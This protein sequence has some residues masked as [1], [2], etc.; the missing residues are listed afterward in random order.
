MIVASHRRSGT[1]FLLRSLQLTFGRNFQLYKTHILA[2]EFS[3]AVARVQYISGKR[4]A[5]P[6]TH[7]PRSVLYI[8]RDVRD[9]L[10]SNYYWWRTSAE[11]K[12]GGLAPAFRHVSPADYVNGLAAID[13]VPT[14]VKGCGVTQAHIDHGMF[15]DPAGFWAKHVSSY[16]ESGIAIIRFE[17]LLQRPRKTLKWIADRFGLPRPWFPRAP[18]RLVGHDP[19]KGIIGDHVELFDEKSL[20]LI[21]KKAGAVMEQCGYS[22]SDR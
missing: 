11:S 12:C 22:P 20:R 14:P 8:V 19:R 3:E 4:Q 17:D 7:D 9:S 2:N 5:P 1:H 16:L 15:S 21:E 6:D 13:C 18:R 10:T